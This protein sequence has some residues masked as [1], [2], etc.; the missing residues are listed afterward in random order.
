MRFSSISNQGVS[1]TP[2]FCRTYCD[3]TIF[4]PLAKSCQKD[5][6][7]ALK[8]T[9]SREKLKY[10]RQILDVENSTF[11]PLVFACAGGADLTSRLYLGFQ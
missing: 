1:E 6:K 2:D 9:E 7:N 4:N 10:G 11:N 3:V 8:F 5:I